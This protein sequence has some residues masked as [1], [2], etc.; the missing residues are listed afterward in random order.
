M[1][2]HCVGHYYVC[3]RACQITNVR[4]EFHYSRKSSLIEVFDRVLASTFLTITAQY[5]EGPSGLTLLGKLPGTT[6]EYAGTL[7]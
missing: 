1:L 6:T 7:P 5:N 2:P 3:G 4:R